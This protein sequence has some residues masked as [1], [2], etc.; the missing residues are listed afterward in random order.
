M[1]D[2]SV[3]EKAE[4]D[5]LQKELAW[6]LKNEVHPVLNGVRETLQECYDCL[7]FHGAAEKVAEQDTQPQR[8]LL[9]CPNASSINFK[10]VVTLTGDCVEEADLQF[11]HKQGKEHHLFRTKVKQGCVWRLP[12][13]R[14]AGNHLCSALEIASKNDPTYEYKSV[15][16]V[17]LL[18]DELMDSLLKSRQCLSLPKRK[19]IQDLLD[20]QQLLSFK[21][22][23]PNDVAISFYIHTSKLVLA[24]YFLHTNSQ[25]QR[26]EIT[27]RVQVEAMVKW[28]NEAIIF[29]TLSLQQCQ[30]LKDKLMAVSK[31]LENP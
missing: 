16:E 19:S 18:L 24:L 30:Q 14:D 22:P 26:V 21:P 8:I 27:H 2:V 23:L 17:F 31:I 9:T 6:L 20:S 28:L 12:Q 1:G 15:K 25:H 29:F 5:V 10:S 13:I 11:K 7:P 3:K 4:L